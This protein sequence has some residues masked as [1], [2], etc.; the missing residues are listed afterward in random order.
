[1][2]AYSKKG[3]GTFYQPTWI[4]A[5]G[6]QSK[7]PI[8]T[9]PSQKPEP[10]LYICSP[11][12]LQ[13]KTLSPGFWTHSSA[14]ESALPASQLSLSAVCAMERPALFCGCSAARAPRCRGSKLGWRFL[15]TASCAM[16]NFSAARTKPT[17]PQIKEEET[18]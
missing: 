5:M 9:L 10:L 13:L 1:V 14:A 15:R 12:S 7:M 6:M 4:S 2:G 3:V 8:E 18:C 17:L 11:L 16:P